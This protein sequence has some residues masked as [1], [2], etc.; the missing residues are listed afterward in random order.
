MAGVFPA[1]QRVNVLVRVF[2]KAAAF[3]KALAPLVRRRVDLEDDTLDIGK[4]MLHCNTTCD[5]SL[6]GNG[7]EDW[8]Y[9]KPSFAIAAP[10][11]IE[12]E[13]VLEYAV[14]EIKAA[15]RFVEEQT[16]EKWDWASYFRNMKV[17]NEQT[18]I[19]L[20]ILEINKTPY[21]QVPENVINLYRDIYYTRMLN[22]DGEAYLKIDRKIR[23]V[24]H[25]GYK[26]RSSS[27]QKYATVRLYGAFRVNSAPHSPT[28]CLTAGALS[29]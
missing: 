4:C 12:D 18:R 28:G 21:P 22:A 24:M 8:R 14:D 19:F 13:L 1:V 5:T 11:H 2:G 20:E 25:E 27:A 17:L 7:I 26:T 9:R 16:G 3:V 23:E 10:E 29:A 15:I 6:M